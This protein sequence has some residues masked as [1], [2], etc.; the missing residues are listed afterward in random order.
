[1]MPISRRQLWDRW[2]AKQ[3]RRENPTQLTQRRIYIL[4]TSQGMAFLVVLLIMLLAAINYQNSLAYALTFLLASVFFV[5]ILHTYRNLVGL[6]ISAAGSAPVFAGD[7][8]SFRIRL[9]GAGRPRSA[10]VLQ[11]HTWPMFG[12]ALDVKADALALVDLSLTANERGHLY[13]GRLRVE[14][15]F[16]LGLIKAWSWVDLGQTLLV[17][18]RPME[19]EAPLMSEHG[20]EKQGGEHSPLQAGGADDYQG[21]RAY[22]QGDSKRRLHWKAYSRGQGLLIKDFATAGGQDLVL[23]FDLLSGPVET[24]LSILCYWV[25]E[26]GAR[27]QVFSLKLPGVW[28]APDTGETHLEACLH[29]LAVHGSDQ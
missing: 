10:V 23:D 22:Q 15:H 2:L 5:S 14:S 1:M 25:L 4:P 13:P 12:E 29:A 20:S 3:V 16:P 7:E 26:L 11:W 6:V 28:L 18:P 27:R 17:Y 21:L 19:G 24:R 9:D 8:A